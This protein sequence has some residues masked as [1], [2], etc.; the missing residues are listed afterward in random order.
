M[1]K[2]L[3]LLLMLLCCSI[4]AMAVP[5][6]PGWHTIKQSDGTT[7][8]VQ[9]VGNA[10]N[11][12]LVTSDG[13][14]VARGD[15]GDYYYTSSLTGLTTMR[16]HEVNDRTP[17]ETAFL[18]AQRG[19]MTMPQKS[20]QIPGN[21]GS[22][23]YVGGSNADADVPAMGSRRI[24]IIL[25]EYQ[26]KKFNNTRQGIIDAMLTGDESV[27]QYFRD[28]SNGLYEPEFDVYGIYTLSQNRSY[29]GANQ[30]DLDKGLG[31]MVTEACQLASADGVS[32]SPYD[33]NGDDYCDVVIVIYAGVGEAQASTTHPEAIWPCNWYLSSASYYGLGGNGPF[34]PNNN[35][36]LVDMFAVFN[37][38]Y[39]SN[40]N[41]TTIDGIGTFT[42]EFGHCLGLPDMY[43]TGNG[44]HYGMGDWDIMCMGCY[45]ND[46]FTPPGY[47]AYEKVFMGWVN[48]ITPQPGTYYTL[49]VW[50]QKNAATDKAVCIVSDIN[51]NE[52]FILENRKRQGW[53]RYMPGEGIMITHVTYDADRWWENTVNNENIQLMTIVPA[54]NNLSYYN[55]NADLWPRNG[56]TEFTNNSTPPARLYMKANGSIVSNA[57]SLSK[58]VT[59]MVI[60]Q[61]GT[62]SFWY[63]KG[64]ATNPVI[65]VSDEDIDFGSVMMNTGA[66][67][68]FNVMGQALT[69]DVTLTLNDD[70]G[71]FSVNPVAISASDAAN[72]VTVTVAFNPVALGKC[73]ATVTLSSNGAQD[74]VV[75]LTG[76]GMLEGYAPVMLPADSAFINLNKFR[77]DWTDQTPAGN[78]ESYTL[79]VK[80]KPSVELLETADFSGVP[81][82]IEDGYLKDIWEETEGYL[83][84]GWSATS[85]L[86][87][88]DGAL[89]LAYSGSIKTPNYNLEG[90]D[91]VTVVVRAATYASNSASMRVST[92]A[93]YQD[94]TLDGT[95]TD[96]TIV[97]D[98]NALD[99]VRFTNTD[100]NTYSSVKS[101]TVYAGDLTAAR[102]TATEL[103]DE[104]NRLITGIIDN[105]YT[106][107]NLQA[108]GTFV[109]RVKA[110]YIDGTESDW[111]NKQEVTLFEN[112]HGF[113]PGDV[114]HDGV[115]SIA[116]ITMMVDYILGAIGDDEC[117]PIC[118]DVDGDGVI[119]IADVTMIVDKILS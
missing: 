118:G 72:G 59:E 20:H 94:L 4:A 76:N 98:C 103:G 43:D 54:D 27:G 13:L 18:N 82:A 5:A 48:Y 117:C 2:N 75:N 107:D 45:N 14:T 41:G 50:N 101:V 108:E 119:G 112:G 92:G 58:P 61:N 26:D 49:P 91:K 12:A 113:E 70:Y 42:H 24:P 52:Y 84:D 31:S 21:K 116:D 32:F 51:E 35:D 28:Q 81:D 99:A 100:D 110:V 85:Y 19:N 69:G 65:S 25:V 22:F 29:Y 111:S 71:V 34:R 38:L 89:I 86:A 60:N 95:F 9:A 16:A 97:L 74:V 7:L 64:S 1:K 44:N 6:K 62:A 40:D 109:Y 80:T 88:Y 3:A 96:Y 10:F 93:A 37:E 102:L 30:N 39:G 90:Y 66:T 87:A 47:S 57:G 53:D 106:V 114:D 55:E 104:T 56:K 79:E 77:A 105:F 68:T 115:I 73:N 67:A 36:P 63:M 8:K 15:D 83:P 11:H 17:A 78:V 46:G 33:T 23:K